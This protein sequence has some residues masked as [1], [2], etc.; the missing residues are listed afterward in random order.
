[1]FERWLQET[2][3]TLLD[4][5]FGC[6]AY[7]ALMEV[8]GLI[9]AADRLAYTIGLVLG[10]FVAVM[11]AFNMYKGIEDCLTM[12]LAKARR[13]MAIKS[14]LRWIVMLAVAWLGIKLTGISFAGVIIGL[15]SLKASA[16]FHVYTHI[17]ITNKIKKKGR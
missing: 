7:G 4:L 3:E 11:V 17:Y 13:S 12:D 10:V 6:I 1:M 8:M 5:V 2:N 16:H 14:V 9:L 15:F